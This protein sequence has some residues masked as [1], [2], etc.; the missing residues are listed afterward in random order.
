[1]GGGEPIWREL[2]WAAFLQ[3]SLQ[4][5]VKVRYPVFLVINVP[6]PNED[7]NVINARVAVTALATA[8]NI[9][10]LEIEIVSLSA[11]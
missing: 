1:M 11:E 5:R 4:V 2:T 8:V 10:F 7:I 6:A 9:T 3:S